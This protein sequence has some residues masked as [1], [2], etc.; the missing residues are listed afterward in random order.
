VSQAEPRSEPEPLPGPAS[1]GALQMA[2]WVFRPLPLLAE[3]RGRHGPSVWLPGSGSRR[4]MAWLGEADAVRDLFAGD[5][6]ALHAGAANEVMEG[7]LG[8]G[9]M[10][11][12]DGPAH[13]RERKLLMP[14][15][16]GARMRAYTATMR[17]S[18]REVV[19]RW[20]LGAPFPFLAEM[21]EVALDVLARAVF[22]VDGA[23]GTVRLREVL[24]ELIPRAQDPLLFLVATWFGS[25]RVRGW[26]D[27]WTLPVRL[28][29][30][31]AVDL[32]P[33]LPG[34]RMAR[35]LRELDGLL[36]EQFALR[37]RGE[38]GERQDVLSLLLSARD[39][40]GEPMTDDQLRDEMVTLLIAGHDT[41]AIALAWA[42]FHLLQHPDALARAT[43]E[44]TAALAGPDPDEALTKLPY[45]D[46]VV[47]E[48]MRLTP[49]VPVIQRVTR[50]PVR[51]GRYLVP[52]GTLVMAHT[53]AI[54]HDPALY[55]E[56][57][58]FRPERFLERR[59]G[60]HEHFPFGGGARRC[61]GAAFAMHSIQVVLAEVLAGATLQ[62]AGPVTVERRGVL[63]APSG[64]LL[65]QRT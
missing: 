39:E 33:P 43:A 38:P 61:V 18:A 48:S 55:P 3:L 34:A 19:A 11:L 40:A 31:G 59:F 53:W 28:P 32:A 7:V 64:G 46:A 60:P 8:R 23:D 22:G 10:F 29:G 24:R 44:V 57:A 17:R 45:L 35:L 41:S 50:S 49:L 5:P 12:L 2:R 62:L 56:P 65:V 63:L 21:Q 36:R 47:K 30:V 51:L 4:P 26:L 14:P 25:A 9:S 13:R 1:F 58:V 15:F 6:D 52:E 37:R 27:R 16:H 42:M 54:H 20:P